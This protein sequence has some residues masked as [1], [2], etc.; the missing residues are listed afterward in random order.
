VSSTAA[1]PSEPKF[2]SAY[3]FSTI[4]VN[5]LLTIV[6]S[7]LDQG[8]HHCGKGAKTSHQVYSKVDLLQNTLTPLRCSAFNVYAI[9]LYD[10]MFL[11]RA[12]QQPSSQFNIIQQH[13]NYHLV[14]QAPG[15]HLLTD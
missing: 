7:L 5:L 11:V 12:L 13:K 8:Y 6:E 14:L 15:H 9:D 2:S 10:I 4:P 3:S 1:I